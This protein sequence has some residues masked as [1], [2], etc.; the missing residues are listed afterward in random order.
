M[1]WS[2]SDSNGLR[3]STFLKVGGIYFITTNID[4]S[5]GLFNGSTGLL[6]A[7]EYGTTVDKQGNR[8]PFRV[9][10]HFPDSLIGEQKRKTSHTIIQHRSTMNTEY[11]NWTPIERIQRRMSKSFVI[12]GVQVI[13]SQIPL[14]ACNGMT[15]A[16]CQGATM[17]SVVVSVRGAGNARL[18]RAELYVACSRAT[19]ISGLFIDGQFQP[20]VAAAADD[21]VSIAYGRLSCRPHKFSLQFFQD[22]PVSQTKLYYHNVEGLRSHFLDIFADPCVKFADIVTFVEPRTLSTDVFEFPDLQVVH[23]TDCRGNQRNSEGALI[24]K[25]RKFKIKGLVII[26]MC[27]KCSLLLFCRV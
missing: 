4:V 20:P 7:I 16:K 9:W 27:C 12:E 15:I 14:V 5:D 11:Q 22:L 18:S 26:F 6:K 10:M 21:P 23:R 3:Y 13:R 25:K 1:N 17:T 24:L 19:S 8:V 2:I